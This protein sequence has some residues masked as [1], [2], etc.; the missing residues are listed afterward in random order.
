MCGA[1]DG[2]RKSSKKGDNMTVL[3]VISIAVAVISNMVASPF[4]EYFLHFIS[5]MAAFIAG[6]YVNNK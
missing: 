3:I 2:R 5:L 4:L 6:M 1:K